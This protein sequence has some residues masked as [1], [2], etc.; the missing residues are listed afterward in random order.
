MNTERNDGAPHGRPVSH[1]AA[2]AHASSS[3]PHAADQTHR[4]PSVANSRRVRGSSGRNPLGQSAERERGTAP[5]PRHTESFRPVDSSPTRPASFAAENERA[6][7]HERTLEHDGARTSPARED[8]S[9]MHPVFREGDKQA[10]RDGHGEPQQAF[11]PL[12]DERPFLNPRITRR[13][14]V[15]GGIAAATALAFF[16][17]SAL[18]KMMPISVTVNGKKLDLAGKRTLQAAYDESGL[19][20]TPGNLVDVE[21]QVITEGGGPA[22]R[23]TINGQETDDAQAPIADG[24]T[25]AFADG[26]DV[27]EP[28]VTED[29][30]VEPNP[31]ESGHGPIHAVAA[32]GASGISTVKTGQTSGKEVVIEVKQPAEDR[33]YLRSYP[34]T[35]EDKAIALTFDDGPWEESTAKILDILRDNG[36]AATFFTVGNRIVD[37]GV[38]LV[39]RE[40]EEG[41]QVC[42]HTWDHAAGSGQGVNLGFMTPDEQRAEI[43]QGRQAIADAIGIEASR[44]IRAPGGNFPLEV[45]RNVEDLI[46]ADIGWDIDTLDWKR[47]GAATIADQIKAA[48]PGDIVLM[49]D[50]GGDRSQT[51]EALRVALPYLKER[52]FRFVTM[53]EMLQFPRKEG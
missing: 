36:A 45:W 39:K 14:F 44:V 3:L 4:R 42:T 21:G 1:D 38:D 30:T 25:L 49:H 34:D 20:M 24:D 9:A 26:A 29:K 22:Y 17:V 33:M 37:A 35:G 2:A 23:A 13:L 12:W 46:D 5:T 28:S 15:A 10:N 8:R 6:R 40:H 53:D 7:I 43:E 27:E 50:G 41:H 16:G 31:V 11:I 32:A 47:P 18:R 52:G 19:N 51:A 48:T